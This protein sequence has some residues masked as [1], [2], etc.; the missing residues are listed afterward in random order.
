MIVLTKDQ[1]DELAKTTAD[2]VPVVD[3]ISNSQYV[4]LRAET[5]ANLSGIDSAFENAAANVFERH[6]EILRRLA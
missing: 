6:E 2:A 5:F 4:L 3:P 1:H